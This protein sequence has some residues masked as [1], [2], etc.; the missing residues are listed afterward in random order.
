[1]NSR[2]LSRLLLATSATL[3]AILSVVTFGILP[4][5]VDQSALGLLTGFSVMW[6]LDLGWTLI[7]SRPS[8]DLSRGVVTVNSE[9]L[10]TEVS[11]VEQEILGRTLP[12]PEYIPSKTL[13]SADPALA[14]AQVRI[15]LERSLRNLAER[16]DVPLQARSSVRRLV[17]ALLARRVLPPVMVGLINEVSDVCNKAVH[18]YRVDRPTADVVAETG[19]RLIRVLDELG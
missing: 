12:S 3:V 15:Q 19:E 17:D 1:M 16:H 18:G 4:V 9:M 10:A 2:L 6:F 7:S 5:R 8:D 13:L 14:L 11:V